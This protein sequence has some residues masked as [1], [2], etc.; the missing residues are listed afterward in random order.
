MASAVFSQILSV[1]PYSPRAVVGCREGLMGSS[2]QLMCLL[3]MKAE[4]GVHQRE[5][6][7]LGKG[8]QVQEGTMCAGYV[9]TRPLSSEL[10]GKYQCYLP[11]SHLTTD[12][13]HVYTW[14]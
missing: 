8:Q 3:K 1:S 4:A 9:K 5:V 6:R 12:H 11:M 10:I 2:I 13:G 7:C 14:W